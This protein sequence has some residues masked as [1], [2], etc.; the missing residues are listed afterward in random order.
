MPLQGTMNRAGNSKAALSSAN[1]SLGRD[2]SSII[3]FWRGE[4]SES[5]NDT[6]RL[7]KRNITTASTRYGALSMKL[8]KL[9]SAIHRAESAEARGVI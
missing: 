4:S 3:S 9:D 7:V 2:S 8:G 6:A 5:F 1:S